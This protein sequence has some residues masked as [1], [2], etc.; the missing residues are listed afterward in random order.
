[1]G[2]KAEPFIRTQILGDAGGCF[3][4]DRKRAKITLL[5]SAL[6]WGS[7]SRRQEAAKYTL[8]LPV[9]SVLSLHTIFLPSFPTTSSTSFFSH[10]TALVAFLPAVLAATF[11]PLQLGFM[12]SFHAY[13]PSL[14][15][16]LVHLFSRCLLRAASVE[17]TAQGSG[18][19]VVPQTSSEPSWMEFMV[20]GEV[21]GNLVVTQ[22]IDQVQLW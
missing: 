5:C 15:H 19:I 18:H 13:T 8:G 7:H 9:S 14:T 20:K 10:F 4:G 3:I 12:S 1:M 2:C 22:V 17:G 11:L 16:L 21:G 6:H